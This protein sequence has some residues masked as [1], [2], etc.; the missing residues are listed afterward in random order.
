MVSFLQLSQDTR[1]WKQALLRELSELLSYLAGVCVVC[2]LSQGT[3]LFDTLHITE[4]LF[5]ST[6]LLF[7]CYEYRNVAYLIVL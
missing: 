2:R 3:V 1:F 5:R 6:T 4:E 7:S